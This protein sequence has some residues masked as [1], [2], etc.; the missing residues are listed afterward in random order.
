MNGDLSGMML[1]AP[2][3]TIIGT[4]A[5][6]ASGAVASAPGV[7]VKP[8]RKSTL[9]LVTSSCAMRLVTSVTPVSSR[10]TSSIFL[11]ATWSPCICMY[12]R[13]PSSICRPLA[14][15]GPDS[16]VMSPTLIVSSAANGVATLKAARATSPFQNA[17]MFS[18]RAAPVL[19]TGFNP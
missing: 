12:T 17:F 14:A 19:A 6:V 15:N 13:A 18:S 8:A 4:L 10:T 3:I 5:C 16:A 9:S 11:P 1:V 7:S 2:S